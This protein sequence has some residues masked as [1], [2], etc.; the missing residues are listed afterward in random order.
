MASLYLPMN[1]LSSLTAPSASGWIFSV[2]G[3][4]DVALKVSVTPLRR[5]VTVLLS[6]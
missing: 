5:S 3:L 2:T 6:R 1:V 4:A